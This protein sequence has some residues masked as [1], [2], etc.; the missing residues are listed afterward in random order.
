MDLRRAG[1]SIKTEWL[2]GLLGLVFGLFVVLGALRGSGGDPLFL[3]PSARTTPTPAPSSRNISVAPDPLREGMGHDGKFFLVQAWDPLYLSRDYAD[4]L[5]DPIYRAR[6]MLFPLV[7]GAGGLLPDRGVVW[8]LGFTQAILLGLGSVGA[9]KLART[10][11][12]TPWAGL[13]FAVNPGL[14]FEVIIGGAGV[15]ALATAIWGTYEIQRG[16]I[17]RAS[18]WLMLS[19]LTR[20]VMV[21]YVAG[22]ALHHLASK[23]RLPI[24]LVAPAVV[25][26]AAWETYLRVRL[27]PGAVV[28]SYHIITWPMTGIVQAAQGW[29]SNDWSDKLV[30]GMVL[31]SMIM[32]IGLLPGSWRSPI[33]SGAAAFLVLSLLLSALVWGKGFDI[34][35]GISPIFTVLPMLALARSRTR[36][37]AVG[38]AAPATRPRP[39]RAGLERRR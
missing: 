33:A 3:L 29:Q 5:D 17:W 24:R 30:L 7:V 13:A 8:S 20:E 9:A 37:P 2:V 11:G 14:F 26:L 32:F 27:H 4:S 22:L 1:N 31:C 19:V 39:R 12:V 35:R 10:A 36:A 16:R 18:M 25:G 21:V 6:R 38:T 28:S 34:S 15:L 23:R